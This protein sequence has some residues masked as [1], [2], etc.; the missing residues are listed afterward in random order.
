MRARSAW[1]LHISCPNCEVS[2][3]FSAGCFLGAEGFHLCPWCGAA[4]WAN[5]RQLRLLADAYQRDDWCLWAAE[6]PG[7]VELLA[8][9]RIRFP[10][11]GPLIVDRETGGYPGAPTGDPSRGRCATRG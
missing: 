1:T 5:G 7:V 2:L 8:P 9:D 4:L 11:F 3:H 10:A 6:L